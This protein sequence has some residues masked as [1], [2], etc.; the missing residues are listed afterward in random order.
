M[1]KIFRAFTGFDW[2]DG[3]SE[4]NWIIHRVSR[5]ECEEV[6]FNQ[7][8]LVRDDEKHSGTELR[9]HLLGKTNQGRLLYVVFTIRGELIRIISARDMSKKERSVYNEI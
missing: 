3:N 7:P 6:F 1:E 5:A 9:W 8:V 2:D 4:K